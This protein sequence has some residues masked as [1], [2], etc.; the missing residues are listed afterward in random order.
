[1]YDNC[2]VHLCRCNAI[3]DIFHCSYPIISLQS[4]PYNISR[5]GFCFAMWCLSDDLLFLLLIFINLLQ[6]LFVLTA[7][8]VL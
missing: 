3:I 5:Y 2:G 1:M 8:L 7:V 6:S 4:P